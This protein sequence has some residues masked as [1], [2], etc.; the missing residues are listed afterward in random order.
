MKIKLFSLITFLLIPLVIFSQCPGATAIDY[1]NKAKNLG[2]QEFSKQQAYIWLA[3]YYAYKC[4][5]DTGSPRSQQLVGMING[6]VDTYSAYTKNAYG[7]ISKVSTCKAENGTGNSETTGETGDPNASNHG[8]GKYFEPKKN[9]LETLMSDLGMTETDLQNIL[10]GNFDE[11]ITNMKY[12]QDINSISKLTGGNTELATGMYNL[13]SMIGE[14]LNKPKTPEQLKAL[15]DKKFDKE[16]NVSYWAN[17][18]LISMNT[19]F[20]KRSVYY[21]YKGKGLVKSQ[22]FDLEGNIITETIHTKNEFVTSIFT[23]NTK[24]KTIH[25]GKGN[26]LKTVD[27]ISGET[28][29]DSSD[30]L[31]EITEEIKNEKGKRIGERIL[32]NGKLFQEIYYFKKE[33][34]VINFENDI[35]L[36]EL[37]YSKK[38]IFKTIPFKEISFDNKGNIILLRTTEF[39]KNKTHLVKQTQYKDGIPFSEQIFENGIVISDKKL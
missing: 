23:N 31:K 35:K 1:K 34:K 18:T 30:K 32:K 21:N 9:F 12:N 2:P 37:Y 19:A 28:I 16:R 39:V 22:T 14:E 17:D 25:D 36:S 8:S 6:I 10:S 4:E 13:A 7:S 3:T 26:V 20:G 38:G 15:F 29:F 5:C 11:A 24:F 33:K 27:L